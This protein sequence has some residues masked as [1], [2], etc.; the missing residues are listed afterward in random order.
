MNT[1]LHYPDG[2]QE[3]FETEDYML[4]VDALDAN[5]KVVDTWVKG[6]STHIEV[7]YKTTEELLEES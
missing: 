2:N 1:V 7:A 5:V 3:T 4:I 6:N